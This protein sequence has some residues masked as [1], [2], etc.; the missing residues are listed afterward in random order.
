MEYL[1]LSVFW[2][3]RSKFENSMLSNTFAVQSYTH[4]AS[5]YFKFKLWLDGDISR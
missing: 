2:I 4:I 5:P 3:P 1:Y